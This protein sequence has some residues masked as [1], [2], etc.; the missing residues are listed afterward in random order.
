MN[1]DDIM[2]ERLRRIKDLK[3]LGGNL[4]VVT[5]SLAEWLLCV[6]RQRVYQLVESGRLESFG[7]GGFR[8]VPLRSVLEFAKGKRRRIC[9]RGRL[10]RAR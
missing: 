5:P 9:K 8:L 6:C 4:G 10:G 1:G 2:N 7:Q 3:R